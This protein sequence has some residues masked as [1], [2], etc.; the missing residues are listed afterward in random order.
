M[1]TTAVP[2]VA[3][4]PRFVGEGRIEFVE[5]PVPPPGPGQLLV[6]VGANALC[7]SE[8]GQ[9]RH[10]SPDVTPGHEAAGV[11]V[12]VGAGTITPIGTHGVIFLMD[13]CGQCRSCRAGFTNQ[14]QA[15][16]ADYGFN[17]D[18]G[19]GPFELINENV[20]FS[21]ADRSLPAAELTLL[22]D[23]IG[24]GGHAIG[25][26]QLVRPD[27]ESV[28]IAGA[29]PIG[30]AVLAMAK[31]RLGRDV[32][33]VIGDIVPY[34]LQ[35][36][37]KLG[38]LPVDLRQQPLPQGVA[39][40]G[41]GG[42][43]DVAFDTSGKSVARQALIDSLGQRGALVCVGHGEGIQLDVT[44]HLIAPE[45]AVL[46]SEYFRFDELP[47]NL[48]TLQ[49]NRAYLSQIITHRFPVSE[50]Q[51]AFELFFAGDTG[52]VVIEQ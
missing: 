19:Y 43:A 13:F 5:R 32:P 50:V 10:G 41:L 27:I 30:L 40:H 4:A 3:R 39:A 42:K 22:L 26:A 25:R 7:G 36:A 37:E 44:S 2:A 16:R 6:R 15:K 12:A 51:H 17:R 38:G 29:G 18:G 33:V 52:K 11:V 34:R 23:V 45:R 14:C 31:L 24:T 35:L 9:F 21:V 49:A 47:D 28:V 48:Q 1:M 8:R 20:F 46:G